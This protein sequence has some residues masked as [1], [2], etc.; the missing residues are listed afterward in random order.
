MTVVI[1]GHFLDIPY[2]G[3]GQYIVH[4]LRALR[5][6]N[7]SDIF[8]PIRS[9]ARSQVAKSFFEHVTFPAQAALIGA[10]V[11]HVPYLGP[12]LIRPC[13]LVVTVHDLI[14][15]AL[16]EHRG[17]P[18]FRLYAAVALAA[19]KRAAIAIADSEHTKRDMTRAGFDER[20]IRVIHLA[21]DPNLSPVTDP[22]QLAAYRAR[23]GL[24][25]RFAL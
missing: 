15:L 2:T 25:D 19:A 18:A 13:P 6:T 1:N 12:P 10:T 21:A 20:R 11:I 23:R 8:L 24:P 14:M 22:E 17:R 7:P 9:L 5:Q 16:P 3:S 4:L